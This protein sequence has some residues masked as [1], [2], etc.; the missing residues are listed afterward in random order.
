MDVLKLVLTQGM[1]LTIIGMAVGL[2]GAF[3]LT[4][5]IVSLLYK[6]SATDPFT[7]VFVA[8]LF[9]GVALMACYVPARRA[10]KADPMVVLRSE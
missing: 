7:F 8:F 9:T 6:T 3:A 5:S 4:R 10:Q 2:F 1:K